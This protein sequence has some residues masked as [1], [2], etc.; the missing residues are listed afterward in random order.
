[1]A[2]SPIR[3]PV[4]LPFEAA[5]AREQVIRAEASH[6]R[7]PQEA[8]IDAFVDVVNETPSDAGEEIKE[9]LGEFDYVDD[10]KLTLKEQT[11]EKPVAEKQAG[12]ELF[13]RCNIMDLQILVV[14]VYL[15]ILTTDFISFI[16]GWAFRYKDPD[17][18]WLG[19]RVHPSAYWLLFTTVVFRLLFELSMVYKLAL[20]PKNQNENLCLRPI[21]AITAFLFPAT[22]VLLFF[23][24]TFSATAET[25]AEIVIES[26]MASIVVLIELAGILLFRTRS[27]R[28]CPRGESRKM[29]VQEIIMLAFFHGF[30]LIACGTSYNFFTVKNRGDLRFLLVTKF[31]CFIIGM[32]VIGLRG[33]IF[34]ILIFISLLVQIILL[35]YYKRA[36]KKAI[37]AEKEPY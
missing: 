20:F 2:E 26:S 8:A 14:V 27:V 33:Y 36:Q 37:K 5:L 17:D 35:I 23:S 13:D 18:D 10:D 15:L 11:P 34:I 3:K 12:D 31:G 16:A 25:W 21:A 4:P 29:L 22:H 7:S 30:P 6:I 9:D 24:A 1:M 28:D 32:I 19:L